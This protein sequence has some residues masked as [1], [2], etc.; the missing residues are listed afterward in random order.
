MKIH[1]IYIGADT[2]YITS[3]NSLHRKSTVAEF[4]STYMNIIQNLNAILVNLCGLSKLVMGLTHL[5]IW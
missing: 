1:S 2:K 4:Y 5:S 3:F